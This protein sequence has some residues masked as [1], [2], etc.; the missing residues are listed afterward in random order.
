ML[1]L[2]ISTIIIEKDNLALKEVQSELSKFDELK[3]IET[4]TTGNKGISLIT[5]FAPSLIF[6]NVDLPDINGIEFVRVLKSRNINPEVVFLADSKHQ[7]YESLEV[8]PLDYLIKPIADENLDKMLSTLKQKL[9]KKE[10]M[11]RMDIFTN[12][13]SVPTKRI[14][15]QRGGIIIVP[16]D[17]IIYCKAELTRTSIMLRTGSEIKLKTGISE[18]IE[19]INSED[20]YRIGRSH[21]INRKYLRKIDKKQS[22]CHLYCQGKI[23]EVPASKNIL[24]QLEK[25]NASA[26]Y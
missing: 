24:I 14:F 13:N 6:V 11:R 21:C 2:K 17:E 20:F 16:L 19:T 26:M 12:S 23:W 22:K 10:L 9:K 18:T 25:L 15:K 4:A 5:N 8:E 1:N 3:I 7:A